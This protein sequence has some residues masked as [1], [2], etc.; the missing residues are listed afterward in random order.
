VLKILDFEVDTQ[1][2]IKSPVPWRYEGAPD[3]ILSLRLFADRDAAHRAEFGAEFAAT[4][5]AAFHHA[6]FSVVIVLHFVIE[7]ARQAS[8]RKLGDSFGFWSGS[9]QHLPQ[10]LFGN[11]LQSS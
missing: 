6:V 2:L 10:F 3:F 8:A 9:R 1:V 7:S 11:N 4:F 5:T